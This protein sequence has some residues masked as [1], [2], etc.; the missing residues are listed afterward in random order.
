VVT[1]WS[2]WRTYLD[3]GTW[4]DLMKLPPMSDHAA[5]EAWIDDLDAGRVERLRRRTYA[6]V[7]PEGALLRTWGEAD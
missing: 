1:G 3:T 2:T 4:M 5:V 6:E 7:T